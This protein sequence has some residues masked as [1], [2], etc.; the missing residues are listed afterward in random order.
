MTP[1][2]GCLALELLLALDHLPLALDVADRLQDLHGHVELLGGVGEVAVD[3]AELEARVAAP[4]VERLGVLGAGLRGL[5][6]IDHLG[7]RRPRAL[8]S[9]QAGGKQRKRG[10][11]ASQERDRYVERC[12]VNEPSY[13]G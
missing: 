5:V 12:M 7:R 10:Q 3:A 8:S 6:G 11:E 4:G 9:S 2:A 13:G 1:K